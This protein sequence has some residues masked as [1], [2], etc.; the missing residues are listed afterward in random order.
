MCCVHGHESLWMSGHL[1]CIFPLYIISGVIS[2]LKCLQFHACA[3][4]HTC[5]CTIHTVTY[6][7]TYMQI[8]SVTL[9]RWQVKESISTY[10]CIPSMVVRRR[11]AIMSEQ[12]FIFLFIPLVCH[13]SRYQRL[14]LPVRSQ[15]RTDSVE[16][17]DSTISSVMERVLVSS[18]RSSHVLLVYTHNIDVVRSLYFYMLSAIFGVWA[19]FLGLYGFRQVVLRYLSSDCVFCYIML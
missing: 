11:M 12:R 16:E 17:H 15:N 4:I 10:L 5:V 3:Y 18:F 13:N 1:S 8:E 9:G 6:T 2:I 19:S 14:Y 7:P